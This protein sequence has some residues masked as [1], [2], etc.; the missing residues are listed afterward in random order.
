MR[1]RKPMGGW[2]EVYYEILAVAGQGNGPRLEVFP[3][4]V[5][6]EVRSLCQ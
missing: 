2:E 6:A 1:R 3:H 4:M 5:V